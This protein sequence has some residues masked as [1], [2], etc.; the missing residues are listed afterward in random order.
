M[1]ILFTGGGTGGHIL[2]ILAVAREI[3]RIYQ[4]EKSLDFYYIGPKDEFG[5]IL[6]SQEGIKVKEIL[7]GK[8]RRY[9]TPKSI[10]ENIIDI[11]FKVPIGIFQSF[12]HIF[13]L[14]PDLIF[15]KGGYGSLPV[16]VTGWILQVPILLHES[17]I[18][19][20]LAN[21]F[22]SK[23]AS[24][25]FTS[26]PKTEYFSVKKIIITGNPIRKAV[27]KG[28]KDDAKRIFNLSG[29]KPII[30]ILGGSQGAQKIND[31][32][33]N[34]L[35]EFLKEFEVIHQCGENNFKGVKAEA[36]VVLTKKSERYYHLVPF[37]KETDLRHA[38]EASGLILSRAGSGSI[39]EISA[40]G[41]PSILV[42]LLGA[43]QNHQVKNAYAYSRAK[44]TIVIEEGNLTP[45]FFLE[46]LR[47]LFSNPKE[48]ENMS[49]K[50]KEF[51][52]PEA[53]RVISQYIIDYL[54][55][56]TKK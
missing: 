49:Q 24:K 34:I 52:K 31:M 22:L 18:S 56:Q 33:L 44:A 10:L 9:L 55:Q 30:L 26:F 3:R 19:P 48:L 8:I 25:V 32:I 20:G 23:F 28:S 6:L 45:N 21:K 11:L 39:F 41:K 46:K 53:G 54:T 35:P 37:L 51:S 2:P 47:Y 17:D 16:V 5:N 36:K 27:L 7:A 13:F 1:K 43:A 50:A 42:P 12:F 38:Y 4:S 15:S 40:L 14:A 29:E